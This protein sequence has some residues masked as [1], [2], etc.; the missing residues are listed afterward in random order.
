MF[1]FGSF[2]LF[3]PTLMHGSVM[4]KTNETRWSL[5]TR[6]KALFTPYHSQEKGLGSF[7]LPIR[8]APATHFGLKYSPPAGMKE[9]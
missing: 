9:K 3:S 2:L 5:N 6:F 4:N 1:P 7:Y 8:T